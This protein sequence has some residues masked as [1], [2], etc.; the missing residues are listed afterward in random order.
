MNENKITPAM[1]AKTPPSWDQSAIP[2]Y[3]PELQYR[4]YADSNSA[5]EMANW[6]TATYG[7]DGTPY[8]NDLD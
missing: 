6:S 4:V 3:D 2:A 1:L 7:K 8:D 5:S